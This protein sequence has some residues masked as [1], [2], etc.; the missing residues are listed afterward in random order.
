MN[1]KHFP[2]NAT[3]LLA[4]TVTLGLP[5]LARAQVPF[6]KPEQ[7]ADALVE[8]IE[9]RDQI[10]FPRL[11]GKD[12]RK[13]LPPD[14]IDP[15]DRQI[16]LDKAR[17][18][19][20][21][22]VKDGRGELVVGSTDPWALPL[23]L[24]QG[25]DGQWRFDPRGG[26]EAILDR[27]IGA[28]ERSAMQAALAYLDAQREYALADRNGDGMLEYAQKLG[29]SPGKRDGLIW[30]ESLGDESPLGESF[31]PTQPGK[32]YH[33]YR[34]R[35]LSAQGPNAKGG[36]RSYMIGKRMSNGYA[37]LAWPVKYG[38]TGVMTFKVNQDGQIFER[39]LGPKTA[40]RAAAIKRFDPDSNWKPT[41]P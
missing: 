27:V 15:A 28:N 11:L 33:G 9:K 4:L 23:P 14:G 29:S 16:F 32:G 39:D 13:L 26:R 17:E 1:P 5:L 38:E 34:F 36:A 25:K 6:V 41:Q 12:W 21:V 37:L 35:I 20:T 40:E 7:A 30:S 31:L 2:L 3:A 8:A 24:V 10:A 18:S 19:R 22:N